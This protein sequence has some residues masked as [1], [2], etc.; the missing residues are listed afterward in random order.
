MALTNPINKANI[1]DRF[2][3]WV[4]AVANAGIVWGRDSVP[5]YTGIPVTDI[6][7]THFEGNVAG[8]GNSDFTGS[9]TNPINGNQIYSLAASATNTYSNI[10]NIR[11]I[12]TVS[13][14]TPFTDTDVYDSTQVA[15]TTYYAGTSISSAAAYQLST[16]YS[17]RSAGGFGI[18]DYFS[19]LRN[20][21]N[22]A[23]GTTVAFDAT[24][25]KT[26]CHSSCHT[27]CH[28]SRGRR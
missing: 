20:A 18:D 24:M 9:M 17:I 5:T 28:S 26:I 10:R 3:E 4:A 22:V 15:N 19:A 1:K 13:G 8:K 23:R 25:R 21:Y 6:P 11:L 16:G 2:N 27:S 7:N 14:T 12:L